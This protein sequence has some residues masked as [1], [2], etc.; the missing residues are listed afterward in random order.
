MRRPTRRGFLLDFREAPW[1]FLSRRLIFGHNNV[2]KAVAGVHR[3]GTT[4][5]TR[6][7]SSAEAACLECERSRH[8]SRPWMPYGRSRTCFA[9]GSTRTSTKL[10]K[11]GATL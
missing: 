2:G 6:A 9:E 10:W 1:T 5:S 4:H 8:R 3:I 7:S 11:N